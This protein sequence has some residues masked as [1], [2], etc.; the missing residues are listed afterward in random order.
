M[1]KQ[2]RV[3]AVHDISCFGKCS[4]TVALP[5]ISA[6]GLEAV[7]LPTAVLS[8]HTGWISGY[9]WRDLTEDI[10][11]IA[12]HWKSLDLK[13][14]AIYTGYL[15]SFRQL[16]LVGDIFGA[17][18]PEDGYII[19]DPVMADNGALYPGFS[20][21]FPKGM[22]GLCSKADII[23]PNMTEAALML[24]EEYRPEPYEPGY[25]DGMLKKLSGLGPKKVV[26]TGV[27]FE[28]GRLGTACYDADTGRTEYCMDR[29]VEGSYHGTGDVF[30][31]AVTAAVVRGLPLDKAAEIAVHFT[32][33]SIER[34]LKA[35]TDRRFGVN[36]EES[37]PGMM[38]EMGL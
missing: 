29:R 28:P 27:S 4:L 5:I 31:S 1:E 32:V 35:G 14:D 2:K 16:E 21:D 9:T 20:D 33:E 10:S 12:E 34:T 7:A 6:A 26:L 25:V 18:R 36:F 8:T 30:A 3:M 37:L 38:R 23:L 19:V 11:P 22:A 13:F 24:G 15:G 17:F